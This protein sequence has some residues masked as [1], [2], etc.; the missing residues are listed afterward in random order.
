MK[1][2]RIITGILICLLLT[3]GGGC[4]WNHEQS[5]HRAAAY[6]QDTEADK[7]ESVYDEQGNIIYKYNDVKITLPATWK[8]RYDVTCLDGYI[9][10][11]LKDGSNGD[12]AVSVARKSGGY[13]FGIYFIKERFCGNTYGIEHI[14][15]LNEDGYY[16]LVAP[17]TAVERDSLK[18]EEWFDMHC[19]IDWIAEHTTMEDAMQQENTIYDTSN[20][21]NMRE[22]QSGVL[23]GIY[24]DGNIEKDDDIMYLW[25]EEGGL[26]EFYFGE[27]EHPYVFGPGDKVK[28]EYHGDKADR[29]IKLTE[30][31][32]PELEEHFFDGIVDS[33]T[34]KVV[35]LQDTDGKNWSIDLRTVEYL[36]YTAYRIDESGEYIKDES[37]EYIPLRQ[38]YFNPGDQVRVYYR[39][40]K[41]NPLFIA[42][43]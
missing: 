36:P 12:Y 22:D 29:I 13:L 6:T 37:G 15:G 39:G 41:E 18:E 35:K 28:V 27:A 3:L 2:K 38:N 10:F 5:N 34:D 32:Q 21:K 25:T 8:E 33:E 20:T 24:V 17:L 1:R 14:I 43:H 30:A 7:L 9:G 4:I 42:V 26:Y 11:W 16:T 31:G 40:S 23:T 19:D